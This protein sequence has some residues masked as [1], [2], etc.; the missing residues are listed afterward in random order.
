MCWTGTRQPASGGYSY[1][2][3]DYDYDPPYLSDAK[4]HRILKLSDCRAY[5]DVWEIVGK[6]DNLMIEDCWVEKVKVNKDDILVTH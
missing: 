5:T 4:S 3:D 1:Y 2:S 6:A